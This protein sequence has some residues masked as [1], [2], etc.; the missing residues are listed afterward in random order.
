MRAI[1]V[2]VA[3]ALLGAALAD[4]DFAHKQQTI[5]RLL[6][7][8]NDP[9]RSSY[10]DLKEAANTW[11]PRDHIDHCKDGGVAVTKIMDELEEERLF[12]RHHWFSLFNERQ[13]EE[14]LMLIDSFYQCRTFEHF[15]K[16]AAYFRER[17]NEGEFVYALYVFVTHSELTEG[18]V[19]PP[20]YEVTPH[21]FTNS[22]IINQAYT[23]K[24]T[25][26]PGNF[27]MSFTGTKKNKE[28]RVAY[29]GEDI[30]INSHH[31]HWHMDFPFWWDYDRIDR[32][33]E[34][35]F[36]AHHQL[37]A[38]F[39]AERLSNH[40][41][42]VG[43]LYWDKPI[44]DGFAPHTTYKYGGDFPSRPDNKEFEDVEGAARIRD[45]K[46]MESRI[47]DAIAHGY[48]VDATG[49]VIDISNE[50]GIDIIGDIIESSMYS[51]NKQYYGAL[52]NTA[53]IVLGRQ[54]DPRG[55]YGMPPGVM[56]HF[57]T[58]TRDPAFFRL[59]K[60]MDNIFKEHK[61]NLPPYTRE[62]LS[63]GNAKILDV[64][65]SE[66]STYFEHFEFSLT[67]ALDGSESVSDVPVTA[68]VPRLN[69]KPFTF[70]IK[71][72]AASAEKATVRVF[73]C[74]THDSNTVETD[75]DVIRWRC[76]EMDKFWTQL[77]PGKNEIKRKSLES[78]V[79]IPDRIP[80]AK[81]IQDADQAV[82][83]GGSL[84]YE[85]VRGCGHPERLLLPKGTKNGMEFYFFVAITSG[86]D[87]VH[88]DLVDNEHGS[89]HGYCGIHGDRYP[90]KKPM[91]FPLDR[92]IPDPRDF[93]VENF[94]RKTV[95]VYHKE[96]H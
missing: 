26:T 50:R 93:E 81:L 60:Y 2:L 80:F 18:V 73:L 51:P 88:A 46:V 12:P 3:V 83:S 7:R 5:N 8:I 75:F 1:A 91:G 90:D 37:T 32:K 11:N 77:N 31:V 52:H 38:R 57:E 58:A 42:L 15:M 69:H 48:V 24:M 89:T 85:N 45:L 6:L 65:I 61:D 64:D 94:F 59:H 10:T 84:A 56:E 22:E 95:K 35:F 86:D 20:L 79:A 96:G 34:L 19:L 36:W 72:E 28:Q 14:A 67:N 74:P 82:S 23:A 29:F 41:P 87:A 66:L 25:Q 21:M 92:H 49:N 17:V 62:E 33:G 78:S 30:G 40:L 54:A 71:V 27:R 68:T 70:N 4:T 55:K 39:D 76:M 16:N 63:Y 47:R 44:K 9:I 13:R 43:E 53:H